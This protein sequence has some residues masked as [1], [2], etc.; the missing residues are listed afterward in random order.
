MFIYEPSEPF[1]FFSINTNIEKLF[2]FLGCYTH[3]IKTEPMGSSCERMKIRAWMLSKAQNLQKGSGSSIAQVIPSIPRYYTIILGQSVTKD[4]HTVKS[5]LFTN[6]KGE[7]SLTG[8][9]FV[10]TMVTCSIRG[11]SINT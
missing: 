7:M 5:K 4:T 9:T 6:H 3:F 1:F 11:Q 8:Y 2:N 10:T